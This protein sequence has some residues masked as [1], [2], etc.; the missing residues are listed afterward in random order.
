MRSMGFSGVNNMSSQEAYQS[1]M[2]I[3]SIELKLMAWKTE[4]KTAAASMLI[5]VG[6]ALI[7]E[8]L[9]ANK[10]E[11]LIEL[12]QVHIKNIKAIEMDLIADQTKVA[13]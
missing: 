3:G 4:R 13:A 12:L 5:T 7:A 9:D 1:A 11:L 8:T 6:P 2:Q 10:A